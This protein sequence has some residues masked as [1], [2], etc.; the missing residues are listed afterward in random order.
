V[1]TATLEELRFETEDQRANKLVELRKQLSIVES[2]NPID[3]VPCKGRLKLTLEDVKQGREGIRDAWLHG[4]WAEKARAD[5]AAMAR[6]RR[7]FRDWLVTHTGTPAIVYHAS[8]KKRH[9]QVA[10]PNL[11]AQFK[12]NPQY[13]EACAQ[14]RYRARFADTANSIVYL[15]DCEIREELTADERDEVA[16]LMAATTPNKVTPKMQNTP[17][18]QFEYVNL[19][20]TEWRKAGSHMVRRGALAEHQGMTKDSSGFRSLLEI[21]PER[22]FYP[23]K[24]IKDVRHA[25]K[26]GE[27]PP[28]AAMFDITDWDSK[29]HPP[30]KLGWVHPGK[31]SEPFRANQ[32]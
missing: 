14:V 3:G 9:Y 19:Q 8:T 23:V 5:L 1:E 13:L 27:K 10:P 24:Q 16:K 20:G 12:D 28:V 2:E 17:E 29:W 18:M 25:T 7:I 26:R 4:D 21:H 32:S 22:L 30:S 15:S 6:E 31:K 11:G